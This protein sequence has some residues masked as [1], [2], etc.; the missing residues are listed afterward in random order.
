MNH[1]VDVHPEDLL[2]R[3]QYGLLSLDERSR[4][5]MHCVRC[6]SC[7]ILRRAVRDFARERQVNTADP[8]MLDRLVD[9]AIGAS[10][11]VSGRYAPV[12]FMPRRRRRPWAVA[13]V[14]MFAATGATASFLTVRKAVVE[15]A[16]VPMMRA[17]REPRPAPNVAP[18]VSKRAAAVAPRPTEPV[19]ERI[20][21]SL[22]VAVRAPSNREPAL[23]GPRQ[24]APDDAVVVSAEQ[25]LTAANDARRRRDT[26][27][28]AQ[29]YRQLQRQYPGTREEAASK[30]GFGRLLLDTGEDLSGAVA[31]FTR[32]LAD[33][34]NGTL[35]E[36]ARVG[37]ALALMR[38]GRSSEE[39]QAWLDLLSS[40]PRSVS[41]ERARRR[42]DELR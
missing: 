28:A 31:L 2:D 35:A 23:P 27:Q 32:Y 26:A 22:P 19:P 34:P 21:P 8:V 11:P 20:V 10:G 38:L 4:L 14:V 30:V 37:R 18:V 17:F 1:P 15:R 42:L 29:L 7:A 33:S 3:E 9:A 41:A 24:K 13:A 6:S 40:H 12:S 25:M 16:F 36:E 5:D 39:R